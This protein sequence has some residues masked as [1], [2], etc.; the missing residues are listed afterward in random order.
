MSNATKAAKI[1]MQVLFVLL[2]FATWFILNMTLISYC[3]STSG[4]T[5]IIILI[6]MITEIV[7]SAIYTFIKLD[8]DEYND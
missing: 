6:F 8:G 3:L 4:L 7:F 5:S 1:T 2:V